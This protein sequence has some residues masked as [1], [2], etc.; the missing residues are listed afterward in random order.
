MYA[1]VGEKMWGLTMPKDD[2]TY[3]TF[4]QKDANVY[5]CAKW[6][7]FDDVPSATYEIF[8]FAGHSG[9]CGCPAYKR[10]KHLKA[11]DEILDAGRTSQLPGLKWSVAGGWQEAE[12]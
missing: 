11:L 3:Y 1:T 6:G 2:G 5:E 12:L 10:C 9:K 8:P 4:R 7:E